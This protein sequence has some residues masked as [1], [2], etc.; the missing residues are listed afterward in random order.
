MLSA[1]SETP[2]VATL[3]PTNAVAT[4]ERSE[5]VF[6]QSGISRPAVFSVWL[7]GDVPSFATLRLSQ[8]DGL[9]ATLT[10]RVSTQWTRFRV[11]LEALS[12]STQY[13]PSTEYT[14]RVVISTTGPLHLQWPQLELGMSP[15]SYN[16]TGPLDGLI[17]RQQG[18]L[19]LGGSLLQMAEGDT[20]QFGWLGSRF[21]SPIPGETGFL[22]IAVGEQLLIAF[23]KVG[24]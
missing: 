12:P 3:S 18:A 2:E 17:R 8:V 20:A 13:T 7:R 22:G 4:I 5:D 23:D 9:A 24:A 15:T 11:A 10:Y 19:S 1:D 21:M 14:L 16:T 6:D